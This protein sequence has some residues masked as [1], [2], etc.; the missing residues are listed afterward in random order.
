MRTYGPKMSLEAVEAKLPVMLLT[1]NASRPA[2]F[3]DFA[4]ARYSPPPRP[5]PAAPADDRVVADRAA[6]E[7]GRAGGIDP[8]AGAD[9]RPLH[10]VLPRQRVGALHAV[11]ADRDGVQRERARAADRA[12]LPRHHPHELHD[13]PHR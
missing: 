1:L 3:D 8:A 6:A 7:R 9:A 12:A 13:H 5:L 4:N 2:D 10:D 11:V